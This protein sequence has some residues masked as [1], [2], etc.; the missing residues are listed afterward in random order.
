MSQSNPKVHR[1]GSNK[2]WLDRMYLMSHQL[3]VGGTVYDQC[4]DGLLSSSSSVPL[5]A[6][7]NGS[8]WTSTCAHT[9]GSTLE[10]GP[11]SAPSTAAIRSLLNQPTWS[12]T[13]SH[14]PKPK[15]TNESS[16]PPARSHTDGGGQRH[17]SG[18]R[19]TSSKE[20]VKSLRLIDL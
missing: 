1:T 13:S 20:G 17:L 11:M 19:E 5:R 7:G 8:L 9:C 10:T 3:S 16:R 6:A 12:L 14:T 18:T 2:L 15:I 4:A